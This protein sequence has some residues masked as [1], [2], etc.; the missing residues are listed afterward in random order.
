M[1]IKKTTHTRRSFLQ[2]SVAL[3][4]ASAIPSTFYINHA[5]AQDTSYDG[6]VFDAG[7]AT[8]NVGEWGGGWEE[9]VR[10]ALTNQFEKDFNCKINWT[11]RSRGFRNS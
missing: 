6:G 1:T 3:G 5:W 2:R 7:G 8:L 4:A 9:F 11:A 10:K